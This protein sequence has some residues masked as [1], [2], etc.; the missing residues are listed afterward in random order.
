MRKIFNAWVFRG[1]LVFGV[2]GLSV[3]LS[4]CAQ[5]AET[6]AAQT[7]QIYKHKVSMTPPKDWKVRQEKAPAGPPSQSATPAAAAGEEFA[8]VVFEPPSGG[9]HIAVTATDGVEQTQEFMDRLA[10]GLHA[11]QG[12]ILKQWYEHKL[13][14]PDKENAYH[15]EFETLDSGVGKGRQKG[16]QVQIF[17]KEKVLYS[18]IFTANPDVYDAHRATFLA[19]VD[20]FDRA[21]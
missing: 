3:G 1:L 13:D 2:T 9:G 8:S 15:M 21:K 7:Y 5:K 19:L 12:K 17:T 16:M 14:D 4:G 10:N 6:S 18:L 11:R 20:S